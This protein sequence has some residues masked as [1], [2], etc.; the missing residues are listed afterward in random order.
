MRK[1]IIKIFPDGHVHSEVQGI[2]GKAC[3]DYIRILEE[4]LNAETFSSKYTP[5]YY[6]E[7]ELPLVIPESQTINNT[8]I[9]K[10]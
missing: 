8:D 4:I 1:V 3:T 10:L 6:E 2:K 5:E 9:N 7:Q